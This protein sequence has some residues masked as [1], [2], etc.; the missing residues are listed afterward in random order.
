MMEYRIY[1]EKFNSGDFDAYYS[2]V[3]NL[4]VMAMIAERAFTL[5][6]AKKDFNHLWKNN[7]LHEFLEILKSKNILA[8]I[9]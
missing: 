9:L 6:E 8:I 1:V 3:S 4:D 2:L 7:N 5:D